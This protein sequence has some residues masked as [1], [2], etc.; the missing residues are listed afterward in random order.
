MLAH[1]DEWDSRLPS[2]QAGMRG[3][4][5]ILTEPEDVRRLKELSDYLAAKQ[6]VK[7]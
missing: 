2:V 7:P 4:Q 3:L 1:R 5:K 6:T